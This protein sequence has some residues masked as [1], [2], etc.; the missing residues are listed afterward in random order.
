MLIAHGIEDETVPPEQALNAFNDLASEEDRIAQEQIEQLMET[1]QVPDALVERS[2]HQDRDFPHF[3][4]AGAEVVLLLQSGPAELVLFEGGHDMLYRPG[5]AWPG[6]A[7]AT[8][9]LVTRAE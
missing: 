9:A 6:M 2:T 7:I 5:L 1:R 4:E 8:D 3:E